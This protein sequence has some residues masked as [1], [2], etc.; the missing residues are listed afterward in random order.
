[1]YTHTHTHTKCE[2][3]KGVKDSKKIKARLESDID[4]ISQREQKSDIS[5]MAMVRNIMIRMG[6][7]LILV[8]KI[9]NN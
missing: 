8:I 7:G 9:V 6:I 1:M 5:I 3:T 4:Q 2:R